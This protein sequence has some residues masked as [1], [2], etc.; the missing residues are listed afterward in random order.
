MV[1]INDVA[2]KANV[3]ISTVSRVMNQNANVSKEKEKAVLEAVEELDYIPNGLARGLVTKNTNSVGILIADIA[4]MYYASLV[5]SIE[6]TLNQQGYYTIIGNTEWDKKREEH[7][8]RYLMQKQVDGFILASTVL[9]DKYID[10]FSKKGIPMVVLDREIESDLIDKI[11]INDYNGAYQ[12]T[13]HL[14]ES[15]YDFFLHIAGPKKAATA[16]DRSKAF[17]DALK[18]NNISAENYKILAGSFREESGAQ[19]IADFLADFDYKG[20]RIGIFAANDAA[21]FGIMKELKER[22]L[23]VPEQFGVIGFDDVNF[24]RYADP[25][26]TTISRPIKEIGEIT[27]SILM[28]RIENSNE[29]KYLKKNITLKVDLIKRGSTAKLNFN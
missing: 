1:S 19:K 11:R 3:S 29:G 24:S 15:N 5:K 7:Y 26:L 23:S 17:V 21:A 25:P 8:L 27:A 14:V 20:R 28:E 6:K 9:D 12:A 10:K 18:E 2:A 16:L 13:T 4:N 22:Q